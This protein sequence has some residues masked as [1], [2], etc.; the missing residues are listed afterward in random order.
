MKR[1]LY[2]VKVE[3]E[4]I[5]MAINTREAEEIAKKNAVNEVG[6]YGEC[7]ASIVKHPSNIPQNWKE[8]I[9]YATDTAKETRKCS[10]IFLDTHGEDVGSEDLDELVDIHKKSKP[11][12][13]PIDINPQDEVKPETRPDPKPRDLNWCETKSG[14]P[15]PPL[16]FNIPKGKR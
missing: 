5:V 14:R 16:R 13:I 12:V 7:S 15:L 4:L 9:P 3:T 2:K 1:R 6:V 10:E 11:A 8:V